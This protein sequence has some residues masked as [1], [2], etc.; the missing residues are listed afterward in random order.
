MP[1]KGK[2]FQF[3]GIDI[4]APYK[5]VNPGYLGTIVGHTTPED[6][7]SAANANVHR[8]NEMAIFDAHDDTEKGNEAVRAYR[9][10]VEKGSK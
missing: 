7:Q 3:L 2:Q 8:R 5:E 6:I 10:W 9:N 1:E 4:E